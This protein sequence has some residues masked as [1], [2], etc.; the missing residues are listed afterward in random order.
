[1]PRIER[2]ALLLDRVQ[3]RDAAQ[4]LIGDGAMGAALAIHAGRDIVMEDDFV[5]HPNLFKHW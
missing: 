4:L 3:C 2:R 1:L 5:R